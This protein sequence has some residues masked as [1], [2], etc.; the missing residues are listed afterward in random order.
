MCDR[1]IDCNDEIE[2]SDNRGSVSEIKDFAVAPLEPMPAA[3]GLG[4][5]WSNL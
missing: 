5:S 2:L 4:S 1:R 3:G